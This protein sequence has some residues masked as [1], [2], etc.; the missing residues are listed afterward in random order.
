VMVAVGGTGV[1]V[2][3]GGT[4]IG[5]GPDWFDGEQAKSPERSVRAVRNSPTVE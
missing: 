2:A 5:V 4:M 3:V 1:F